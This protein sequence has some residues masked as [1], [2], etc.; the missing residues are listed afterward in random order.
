MTNREW[1]ESLPD[2]SF[3]EM[4]KERCSICAENNHASC[5]DCYKGIMTWIRREHEEPRELTKTQIL[6][7]FTEKFSDRRVIGL[8]EIGW[9]IDD[10]FSD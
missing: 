7:A 1:L 8:D 5:T 6:E 3:V 10:L 9:T 4:I 2:D